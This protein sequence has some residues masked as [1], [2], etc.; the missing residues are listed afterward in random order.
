MSLADL[1]SRAAVLSAIAEYRDLGRRAFL[2]KYS[3]GQSIRYFLSYEGELFDSK[4]IAGAAHGYQFPALGP[5]RSNEFS[6]G[7]RTVRT[8]LEELGFSVVVLPGSKPRQV[9]TTRVGYVSPNN[10]RVLRDTG[11][12]GTDHRQRIYVLRCGEC[13][14]EYGA[15]GSDIFQ[16]RCP[17]CQN[18]A[19]GL[20][21]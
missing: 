2:S 16:R 18:G 13:G 21:Y 8:K 1:S 9:A 20:R 5:L 12:P 14:A 10:Q 3:F 7:D 15:N 11:L 19:P 17:A 6:G 4:A